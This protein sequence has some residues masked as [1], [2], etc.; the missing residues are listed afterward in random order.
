MNLSNQLIFLD[1]LSFNFHK[2]SLINFNTVTL[3]VNNL[4]TLYDLDIIKLLHM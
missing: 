1:N 3:I 4:C 2:L